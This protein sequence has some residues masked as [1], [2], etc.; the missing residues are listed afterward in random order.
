M[1]GSTSR[2]LPWLRICQKS[3]YGP[4]KRSRT[5]R[6]CSATHKEWSVWWPLCLSVLRSWLERTGRVGN[7]LPL[8]NGLWTVQRHRQESASVWCFDFLSD[9]YYKNVTVFMHIAYIHI[10]IKYMIA[11]IYF[12]IRCIEKQLNNNYCFHY[13]QVKTKWIFVNLNYLFLL[14]IE[15]RC[16][17]IG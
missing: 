1:N 12:C 17:L 10:G 8:D 15:Y 9:M 2:S 7:R 11:I 13:R 14:A 3:S 5:A 16:T 4:L 6:V